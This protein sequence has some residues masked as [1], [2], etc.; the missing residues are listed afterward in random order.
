LS[1]DLY[2]PPQHRLTHNHGVWVKKYEKPLYPPEFIRKLGQAAGELN[3][4]LTA[5]LQD[6]LCFL[7]PFP[8]E[9]FAQLLFRSR[10][11]RQRDLDPLTGTFD[12]MEHVARQAVGRGGDR[13][14]AATY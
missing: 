6:A 14:P 9:L 7:D 5:S 2:L 1:S 4:C 8:E 11:D 12:R 3:F 10:V 13:G